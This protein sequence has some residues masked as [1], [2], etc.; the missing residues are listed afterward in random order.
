MPPFDYNLSHYTGWT[1]AHWEYMLARATYGY[2]L[3]ADLS[4]SPARALF[5]D[6]RADR[7]DA[8]DAL[9][10]FWRLGLA[11]GAWLYNPQNP[12]ALEF[13]GREINLAALMRDALIQGTD[14]ANSYTYW[15]DIGDMDQRIVETS[16]LS[17]ALWL[18]RARV[19]H[20]LLILD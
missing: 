6:D 7:P 16:N 14:R 1:R 10:A 12:S 19:F 5:P 9:E 17:L 15:G 8:V 3:A 13:Q 2:V 11:W 20:E 18:S 4:G